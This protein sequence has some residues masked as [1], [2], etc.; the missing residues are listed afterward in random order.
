VSV[1]VD[2]V[3]LVVVVQVPELP[4]SLLFSPLSSLSVVPL[5]DDLSSSPDVVVV[6]VVPPE[7]VFPLELVLVLLF[8]PLGAVGLGDFAF[9]CIRNGTMKA[10]MAAMTIAVAPRVRLFGRFIFVF[11]PLPFSS[12]TFPARYIIQ[13]IEHAEICQSFVGWALN[14]VRN[15]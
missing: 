3:V 1:V 13:G 6:G 12:R 8:P 9:E 14:P 4:E 5:P 10:P 15:C 11:Y 7:L 2:V